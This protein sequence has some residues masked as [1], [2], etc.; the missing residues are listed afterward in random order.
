MLLLVVAMLL[1]VVAV[2]VEAPD[3]A[4]LALLDAPPAPLLCVEP[5]AFAE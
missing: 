5:V 1:L 4:V 3:P 2:L